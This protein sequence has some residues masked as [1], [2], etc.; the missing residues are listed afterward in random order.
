MPFG[1][2]GGGAPVGAAGLSPLDMFSS[3]P[4]LAE[5][6]DVSP[7]QSFI[8][9]EAGAERIDLERGGAHVTPLG[10]TASK[11]GEVHNHF[12]MRGAVV[13]DDLMRRSE[14]AAVMEA[15][16]QRS[17]A[18]AVSMTQDIARRGGAPQR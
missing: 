14:A 2:S 7:G 3:L 4:G 8:S 16:E 17:V 11:G 9:G 13:T 18:R 10:F 15:S 6:G 5:G 1:F 12:D